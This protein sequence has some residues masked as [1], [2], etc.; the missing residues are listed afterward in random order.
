MYLYYSKD[1][2][3]VEKKL[4]L[5]MLFNVISN[6]YDFKEPELLKFL[7]YM[8][9]LSRLLCNGIHLRSNVLVAILKVHEL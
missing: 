5:G 7:V 9:L 4:L 8:N 1:S 2:W 3:L 6:I